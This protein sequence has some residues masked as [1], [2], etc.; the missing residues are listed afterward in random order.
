MCFTCTI[1]WASQVALVIENP[2]TNA[3]D[4][5]DL[6]SVPGLGRSLGEGNGNPL[7]YFCL[8]NSMDGGD[9]YAQSCLMLRDSMEN[10]AYQPPLCMGSSSKN[11]GMGSHF[12]L[13]GIFLTQGLNPG[14]L[15]CRQILFHLSHQVKLLS[16]V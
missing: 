5:R 14:L 12:H 3:G 4:T 2:P 9:W 15:H 8:E 1:L 16:R 10:V 7:Q 11:T 6:G 13:Q